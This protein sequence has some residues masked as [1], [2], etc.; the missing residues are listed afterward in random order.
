MSKKAW[1]GLCLR[2]HLWVAASSSLE[3]TSG[4]CN[5]SLLGDTE[6]PGPYLSCWQL[7]KLLESLAKIDSFVYFST[8]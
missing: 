1:P 5:F 8:T 4:R 6:N 7:Q 2:Q 3:E